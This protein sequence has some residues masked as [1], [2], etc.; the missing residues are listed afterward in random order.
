MPLILHFFCRGGCVGPLILLLSVQGRNVWPV[1]PALQGRM[2]WPNAL[3]L[4]QKAGRTR[5]LTLITPM[6]YAHHFAL[7]AHRPGL[8][9]RFYLGPRC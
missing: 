6:Y 5:V 9:G 4:V 7:S 1:D 3:A 8:R 2:L